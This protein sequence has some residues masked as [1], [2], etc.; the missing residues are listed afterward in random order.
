MKR[1]NEM[2]KWYKNDEVVEIKIYKTTDYNK[3]KKL[4]GNREV[5]AP[6]VNAIKSSIERIGYCTNPILVN[7][8]FEVIDGQGRLEAL[9]ELG[10]PVLYIIE[11]GLTIE[12]CMGMNI[13][14]KNW[15]LNDHIESYKSQG[16]QSYVNLVETTDKFPT[17]PLTLIMQTQNE[18]TSV[19]RKEFYELIQRGELK[20]RIPNREE[21]ILLNWL[22][23][24]HHYVSLTDLRSTQTMEIL[25]RLYCWELIDPNKMLEQFKKYARKE[26]LTGGK[27]DAI[28]TALTTLYNFS[29]K[30]KHYFADD[31]R[32]IANSR[33]NERVK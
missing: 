1:G 14:M 5:L 2:Y 22:S 16:Y 25:C 20:Y 18:G 21:L 23:N 11:E 24:I 4:I 26:F 12:D 27:V 17:L 3:F 33:V 9:K 29:R 19:T 28:L 15:T 32:S 8:N 10:M 6:R 31:Y 7:E 13:G 30:S